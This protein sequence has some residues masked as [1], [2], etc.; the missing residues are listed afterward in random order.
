[1][2]LKSYLRG[3]GAGMIVAA[4]VVSFANP[5]AKEIKEEKPLTQD[6]LSDKVASISYEE[7]SIEKNDPKEAEDALKEQTKTSSGVSVSSVEEINEESEDALKE[8]K[9]EEKT[10]EKDSPSVD[11]PEE[12]KEGSKIPEEEST[13]SFGE[14][15]DNKDDLSGHINP[16]QD[17]SGFTDMGE[18]VQIK[19]VRGDGSPS[20]CRRMYEAGLIES[21]VE[22][23]S[24]LVSNGY[25]TKIC[26]GTYDIPFG[27]SH[28]EMAAIIT[29][30]K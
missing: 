14:I 2:N 19:I 26:T 7:I 10:E 8:E 15:L 1:M 18:T 5:K 4:L 16:L 13:E 28:E 25:D 11:D 9:T 20:V 23:D 27:L 22:F 3:I 17:E 24:F 30:R 6:T 29:K 12:K 21:A